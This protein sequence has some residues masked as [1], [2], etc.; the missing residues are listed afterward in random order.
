LYLADTPIESLGE[1]ES[2]G[3]GLALERTPIE[4]LGELKSVGGDLTLN[5][6]PLG[7]R[8]KSKMSK[9]E[10]KNKFGVNGNLY[11]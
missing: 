1:L 6:T 2:V 4:S 9:D 11:I 3:G 7:G 10:I 5:K 8:L